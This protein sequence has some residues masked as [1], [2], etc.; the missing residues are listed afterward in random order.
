VIK[1]VDEPTN[2]EDV[3]N[4]GEMSRLSVNEEGEEVDSSKGKN[5][6]RGS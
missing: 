4:S 6:S 1:I 5:V 2:Q 3:E